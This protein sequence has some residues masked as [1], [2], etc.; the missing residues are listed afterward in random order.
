M[1]D[2]YILRVPT[3]GDCD[4][5]IQIL[6]YIYIH[7][8]IYIQ[9]QCVLPLVLCGLDFVLLPK[10]KE[11]KLLFAGYDVLSKLPCSVTETDY[12]QMARFLAVHAKLMRD[13]SDFGSAP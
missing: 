6:I 7:T 2:M 11:Q 3:V 5:L 10:L 1:L 9:N 12:A 13:F 4:V 8:Y